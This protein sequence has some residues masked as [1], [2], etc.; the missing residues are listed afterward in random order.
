MVAGEPQAVVVA[1]DAGH[2]S[3]HAYQQ[4]H[5]ADH[6]RGELDGRAGR[7]VA[8]GAHGAPPFERLWEA[9]LYPPAPESHTATGPSWRSIKYG[10][11]DTVYEHPEVGQFARQVSGEGNLRSSPQEGHLMTEPQQPEVRRSGKGGASDEELDAVPE[12]PSGDVSGQ[13]HGTDKGN[14]GGGKGGGVPPD[15]QP[16]HPA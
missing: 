3:Q 4:E 1:G 5:H 11:S 12:S 13:P 14:K 6:E 8:W 15:Q 7:L 9:C 10:H 2:E 16:Q